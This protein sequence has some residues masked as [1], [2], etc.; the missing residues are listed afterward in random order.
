MTAG[1]GSRY[2]RHL[3]LP[4]VG[5]E[6]QL[7]LQEA[8]VLVVG[9]GGLGSPAL[10]YLAAAGIGRIGLI[11]DDTVDVTNLQ[12]Q[13]LH[14]TSEVGESKA[15][16]AERRISDLNPEVTVEAIEGRLDTTN[17]LDI[18]GRYDIL[19]DG[20]DNFETRYLIG[21]A[22]E[23]LGKPWVFGSI[24]RFEGQVATFNLDGGPNYRDLFPEPPEDGL[25][26][27]CAEAGVLGVLPGIVGSIQATEAIK[28]ILRIGDSLNGKLLVIDA[29]SMDFRTLGFSKDKSREVVTEL[30]QETV[31]S[32]S[33]DVDSPS[34]MMLVISPAEFVKRR[35]SGWDVFLFDVRRSEE[36]AIATLSGTALRI[37][38][39]QVPMRM[40]EIPLD[41]D[42]V[43]YCRTGV[44]S[45]AVARYL[46]S[47]GL[48]KGEVYNLRGGIH[49]WS[50]T[51]NSN[52][53]KY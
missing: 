35:D 33:S 12:R 38:H 43:V 48:A 44:R 41:R 16:S 47:S 45:A 13:I 6:G 10:L 3:T 32:C 18:I 5:P 29:L 25:A 36:E 22:C 28:A 49:E 2:A 14:S 20:T 4:E 37:E 53:I 27:N 46:V 34:E 51:V 23:I 19:I 42:I 26:P 52:I 31:E 8:S 9:A 50:D 15:A 39:N 40:A 21:D 17:A 24:H 1:G 30:K 11:D 7:V